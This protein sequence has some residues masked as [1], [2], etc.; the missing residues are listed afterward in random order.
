VLRCHDHDV[1]NS[2]SRDRDLRN[3]QRLGVNV[4]VY[5]KGIEPAEMR[6]VHVVGRQNRFER[7][8][9]SS[10]IVIV[11]GRNHRQ[12]GRSERLGG[13]A[14]PLRGRVGDSKEIVARGTPAVSPT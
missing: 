7:V 6:W 2:I 9:S 1:V 5:R 11:I 8:L 4:S 13:H 12:T 14:P 3:V 10:G